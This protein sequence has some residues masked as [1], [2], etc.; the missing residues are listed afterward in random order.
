MHNF[1]PALQPQI[2]TVDQFLIFYTS[3]IT[4]QKGDVDVITRNMTIWSNTLVY[5]S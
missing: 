5:V 4:D 2:F 3:S 1:V